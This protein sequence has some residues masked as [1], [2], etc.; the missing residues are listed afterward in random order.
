MKRSQGRSIGPIDLTQ[1]KR[2]PEVMSANLRGRNKQKT[3]GMEGKRRYELDEFWHLR[4]WEWRG[5]AGSLRLHSSGH[6][7]L[8]IQ[9]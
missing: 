4:L 9:L 8:Q 1:I 6:G 3:Y 5:R 7:Q 2:V